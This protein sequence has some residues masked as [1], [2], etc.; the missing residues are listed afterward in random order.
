MATGLYGL[1]RRE[2]VLTPQAWAIAVGT[3]FWLG[4]ATSGMLT[5]GN[6]HELADY[7]WTTTALSF[8]VDTGGDLLSSADPGNGAELTF[9]AGSDLLLSPSIFGSYAHGL[10][11]SKILGFMPTRLNL[12]IWGR[13]LATGGAETTSGF[14][15]SNGSGLVEANHLAYIHI[16]TGA[17]FAIRSAAASDAGS[18]KDTNQHLFRITATA[19]GSVEWFIDDVSQGTIALVADTFPVAFSGSVVAAGSNGLSIGWVHIYYD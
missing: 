15:F 10:A 14:G 16:P 2:H 5:A 1:S 13:F 8:V 4:G 18:A 6:A 7:G 12:E 3:D 19:G 17:N 9:D 11:A